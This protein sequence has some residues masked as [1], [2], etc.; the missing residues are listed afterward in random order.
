MTKNN[1]KT[2]IARL[3]HNINFL[4]NVADSSSA[5]PVWQEKYNC[6]TE[7]IP[8][9]DCKYM[10]IEGMNFGNL[11]TEEYYLFKIRYMDGLTKALRIS[12]RRKLYSIKRII[13]IGE[14]NRFLNII[15]LEIL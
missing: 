3:A 9:S 10:L 1:K 4:E 15:A 14:K 6:F 12:F 8:L 5:D 13:N 2:F 11:I 7:I